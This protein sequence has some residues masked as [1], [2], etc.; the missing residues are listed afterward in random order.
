MSAIR[1]N[2]G[3]EGVLEMSIERVDRKLIQERNEKHKEQALKAWKS[4]HEQL[5]DAG[6][7]H[8]LFGSL[9]NGDFRAHSDIDV[10]VFGDLID[11]EIRST[12]DVFSAV[13]REFG[14]KI[15]YLFAKHLSE[16]DVDRIL[17]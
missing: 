17:R 15:D 12:E 14:V 13:Y 7:E 3:Y 8:V 16:E 1:E 6:V 4:L 9:K 2:I 5:K 10:M 11:A